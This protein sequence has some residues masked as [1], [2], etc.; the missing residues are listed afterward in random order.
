MC[1]FIVEDDR[2]KGIFR[3]GTIVCKPLEVTCMRRMLQRSWMLQTILKHL[4]SNL[5]VGF[6]RVCH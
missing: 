1:L 3:L 5:H 6:G 4:E 2:S